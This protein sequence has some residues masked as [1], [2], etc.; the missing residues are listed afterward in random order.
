MNKFSLLL[1]SLVVAGNLVA[2][3]VGSIASA[4]QGS[5]AETTEVSSVPKADAKM[6]NPVVEN[7]S[8]STATVNQ[9]TPAPS[10]IEGDKESLP[11]SKFDAIKAFF[12][13][14]LIKVQGGASFA[15]YYLLGDFLTK[16]LVDKE[17]IADANKVLLTSY[18]TP[19]L[20]VNY[21]AGL[22]LAVIA[23]AGYKALVSS[24]QDQDD[25]M[26]EDEDENLD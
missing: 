14:G 9:A 5:Q 10:L 16:Y 13:H 19:A 20:L 21:A 3:E 8:I 6:E 25:F 1:M 4:G 17:Y 18:V 22:T 24:N 23:Y 7:A 2:G 26:F 11:V 12:A 15:K